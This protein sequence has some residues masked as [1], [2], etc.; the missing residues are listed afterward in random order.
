MENNKTKKLGLLSLASVVLSAMLGGGIF[1][2][3]KNMASV[4]GA[5]AQIIAWIVVGIGMWFVT[6]M[7]LKL[8]ELKPDL[9]T[10]LYKYGEAGFGKFTGFF[11]SWGYWICECFSNVAYAVLIMSTLNYFFPEKF[12]GGNNWPSVIGATIILWGMTFI[13]AYGI[14][15]AGWVTVV[16]ACGGAPPCMV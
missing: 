9:T 3:P 2:L 16:G 14:E 12:S 8:T 5:K 11:V 1:D 15:Q 4:A 10:G 7:F 13:I 6:S